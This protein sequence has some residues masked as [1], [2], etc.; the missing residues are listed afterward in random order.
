M[1]TL[2]PT[3]PGETY[4]HLI[5]ARARVDVIVDPTPSSVGPAATDV[6]GY[7]TE[8]NQRWLRRGKPRRLVIGP[9]DTR[10]L[11]V[12]V[13]CSDLDLPPEVLFGVRGG[14]LI[15]AQAPGPFVAESVAE[16]VDFGVRVYDVRLVVVLAHEGCPIL[17]SSEGAAALP[18]NATAR[19][20]LRVVREARAR[21][22]RATHACARREARRLRAILDL[23]RD[24][25]IIPAVLEADRRVQTIG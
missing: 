7:L 17:E 10:R 9:E 6:L 4:R 25:E 22:E 19:Q 11:A 21:G 1:A 12:I 18:L 23:P 14:E 15:V 24:V 3:T 16:T 8:G 20:A 13:A 5:E 2:K